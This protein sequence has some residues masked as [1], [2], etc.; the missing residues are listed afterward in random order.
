MASRLRSL[1][2]RDRFSRKDYDQTPL[3]RPSGFAPGNR[4][5]L[6]DRKQRQ[7]I[8]WMAASDSTMEES[9]GVSSDDPAAVLR[10]QTP[11]TAGGELRRPG[12]P[13]APESG[14]ADGAGNEKSTMD[15]EGWPGT[16]ADAVE[17]NTSH[18]GGVEAVFKRPR[19]PRDVSMPRQF[20]YRP[21]PMPPPFTPPTFVDT[22][23]HSGH[24]PTGMDPCP[25][26]P[27]GYPTNIPPSLAHQHHEDPMASP[28]PS[29]GRRDLPSL[30]RRR[31]YTRSIPINIAI[32][33]T[34]ELD[35][36]EADVS[37]PSFAPASYPPRS[38]L[39]PPPPPGHHS[40]HAHAEDDSPRHINVH[41][42]IISSVD[43]NGV[44]WTRHT[45]IYGGGPCLACEA[46]GG[47]GFYGATVP[48]EHRR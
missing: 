17:S 31:S 2:C 40:G 13:P 41:G 26:E 34:R 15:G 36:T 14:L 9:R 11:T 21:F 38:P 6:G 32:P 18:T 16:H 7:V 47:G 45:R 35:Q 3:A 46:A 42:E 5:V 43:E 25:S 22:S 29:S 39:M 1:A 28:S 23:A 30:P 4:V 12:S 37:Y 19:S 10:T 33:A 8:T 20:I 48:P 27:S 24:Y 44:G